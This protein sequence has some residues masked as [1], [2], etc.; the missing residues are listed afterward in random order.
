MQFIFPPPNSEPERAPESRP[1]HRPSSRSGLSRTRSS[2]A[3]RSPMPPVS[4]TTTPGTLG[5]RPVVTAVCPVGAVCERK[6]NIRARVAGRPVMRLPERPH[7]YRTL[8]FGMR[9]PDVTQLKAALNAMG[10]AAGDPATG[11]FDGDTATA[12][13]ALYQQIGYEPATGGQRDKKGYRAGSAGCEMPR[14]IAPPRAK[15]HSIRLGRLRRARSHGERASV[16]TMSGTTLNDAREEASAHP[17]SRDSPSSLGEQCCSIWAPARRVDEVSASAANC[18]FGSRHCSGRVP[19]LHGQRTVRKADAE[20]LDGGT[21]AVLPA[22]DGTECRR[23][24]KKSLPSERKRRTT[25][26]RTR[27]G[28]GSSQHQL[29]IH[30]ALAP[31]PQR[32]NKSVIARNNVRVADPP[33]HHGGTNR[34]P[35]PSTVTTGLSATRFR[36]D[37]LE[38]LGASQG[39]KVVWASERLDELLHGC[40]DAARGTRRRHEE[41]SGD[42]KII[43]RPE[44]RARARALPSAPPPPP[45]TQISADRSS[46]RRPRGLSRDPSP[47]GSGKSTMLNTLGLL[48]RPSTGQFL[49]EGV[50]VS[51]LTD[52]ERA[53]LRARAIGFVFQSFHAAHAHGARTMWARGCVC[54]RAEQDRD[55]IA[56]HALERVGLAHRIDFFPNTLSGGERQ[57]VAIARAVCTS[58]RLLLADEPTGN[59][60]RANSEAVMRLFSELGDDGL[61]VIMITHDEVVAAQAAAQGEKGLRKTARASAQPSPA[62]ASSS[63]LAWR[64]LVRETFEG[65]GVVNGKIQT[66]RFF[67]SGHDTRRDRFWWYFGAA[68]QRKPA[69]TAFPANRDLIDGP[70]LHGDGVV[71]SVGTKDTLLERCSRPKHGHGESTWG[72]ASRSNIRYRRS[73]GSVWGAKAPTTEPQTNRPRSRSQ[74]LPVVTNC[75]AARS[76]TSMCSSLPSEWSRSSAAESASQM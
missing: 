75:A 71:G 11:L 24:C 22:P 60:D 5:D 10:Y 19:L 68:R 40:C 65:V 25:T 61:T 32:P 26:R 54:R 31:K 62:A 44:K 64:D 46:A 51:E 20:L 67:D 42:R 36:R 14:A 28:A 15:P 72:S 50:D 66:G 27:H 3:V 74:R 69:S 13:E 43:R 1:D 21:E 23:P 12:L 9:G 55:G 56:R 8:S 37:S 35:K 76:K 49:F 45:A 30:R 70:C 58:P 57:R 18:L 33:S 34:K 39:A 29:A 48:D 38:R 52:D 41:A 17:G 53:A 4:V 6:V 73:S 2:R 59:L 47:S 63:G 7:A 16:T